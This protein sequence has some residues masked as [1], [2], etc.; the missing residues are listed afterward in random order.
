LSAQKSLKSFQAF[1]VEMFHESQHEAKPGDVVGVNLRGQPTAPFY[2]YP[3]GALLPT[4]LGREMN[5]P[6]GHTTHTA[7]RCGD[8]ARRR[9]RGVTC[10]AD[11]DGVGRTG[12]GSW[13]LR[14]Q[15]ARS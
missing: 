6:H 9:V 13:R 15:G 4:F 3:D 2:A 8:H 14:R 1:T 12:G 10:G 5:R 7:H 11:G